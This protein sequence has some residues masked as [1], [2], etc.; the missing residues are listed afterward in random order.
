[1]RIKLINNYA[2]R[3]QKINTNGDCKKIN[4]NSQIMKCSWPQIE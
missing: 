3:E 1:M 2:Q 4:N